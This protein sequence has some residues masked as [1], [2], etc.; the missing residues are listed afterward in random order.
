MTAGAYHRIRTT[1]TERREHISWTTIRTHIREATPIRAVTIR[2]A[3]AVVETAADIGAVAGV[4]AA[5]I[6]GVA[7]AVVTISAVPGTLLLS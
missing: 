3:P 5:V 1:N 7:A 2:A 6:A 4:D